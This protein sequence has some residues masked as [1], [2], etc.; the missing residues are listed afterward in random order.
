MMND[1][2]TSTNP[3]IMYGW[4]CPKCGNV[5]SP[6]TAQC[7]TC[8]ILTSTSNWTINCEENQNLKW[9][10][11]LEK[12]IKTENYTSLGCLPSSCVPSNIDVAKVR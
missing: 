11:V 10:N 12:A 7:N 2:Q 3:T 4:V 5:W 1:T 8:A 9:E 6:T